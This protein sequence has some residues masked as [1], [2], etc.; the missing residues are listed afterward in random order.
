M[1]AL[2]C[3]C[4]L[5]SRSSADMFIPVSTPPPTLRSHITTLGTLA[6]A[7]GLLGLGAG[8]LIAPE[9]SSQTYGVPTAEPTWVQA[10]G[11]RDLLLGLALLTLHRHPAAQR[12][13]L[14]IILLLPLVDVVLVLRA[15]HSLATAAPHV[16]GVVGIGVLIAASVGG[17]AR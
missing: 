2:W 5:G 10:T 8:A 7:V 4:R 13:L 1:R 12:R 11:M 3:C 6:L 14:P 17:G 16:G 9:W 15:G